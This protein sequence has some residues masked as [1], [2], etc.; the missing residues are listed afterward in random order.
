M[1]EQ[2]TSFEPE[3]REQL[4]DICYGNS[5]ILFFPSL[6]ATFSDAQKKVKEN[7]QH[8]VQAYKPFCVFL[9]YGSGGGGHLASAQAL[10]DLIKVV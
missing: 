7:W 10:F 1:I 4:E 2:R 9:L 3:F 5:G 6:G 8:L